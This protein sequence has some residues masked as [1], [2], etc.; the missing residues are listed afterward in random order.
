M[1]LPADCV[2]ELVEA[3]HLLE[4][5]VCYRLL[6]PHQHLVSLSNVLDSERHIDTS[7]LDVGDCL[8]DTSMTQLTPYN[9][10]R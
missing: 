6:V 1:C 5:I 3:T 7:T 10:K 4:L 9:V 2:P 8:L